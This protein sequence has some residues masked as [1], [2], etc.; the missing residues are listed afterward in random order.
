VKKPLLVT[1]AIAAALAFA[2]VANAGYAVAPPS[3]STTT[4]KPTFEVYLGPD[5][6]SLATVYVAADTQMS[7]YFTPVNELGS[8]TP[9]TPTATANQYTCQPNS[10]SN[11][12]FGPALPPGT[13]TWWLTFYHTDPGSFF[14]TLH[15]S[16]PLSFTVPQP[17]P[18]SGA[19]LIS[20]ADG[21]AVAAPVTFQ[22][23]AP[24]QATMHI[25][26]AITHDR[27][28]NGAPYVASYACGGATTNAGVYYCTDQT[29]TTD[30]IAGVTYYWWAVIN[31]GDSSFVYGP[32]AF[33]LTSGSSGGGGSGGG[34]GGSGGGGGTRTH[35][36]QDAPT[37]PSAA[38]YTGGSIKQT[39]LSAAAY[40]LS[41]FIGAPKSIAVA[42]W[43]TADWPT[44]SGDDAMT[45]GGYSTLAFWTP[46]MPHWVSLSPRVCGSMETLLHNRPA[47]PNRFT[48]N[49]V[50][51][52]THEMMHALG[53]N[54]S[55][56]GAA[57]EPI[58]ECY[59]MQLSIILAIQLGVPYRYAN[60]LS[61]YNLENYRL[62]PPSYQ[63]PSRCR[64][65][66]AWDLYPN[67]PSPP[68]H[69]FAL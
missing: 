20:P 47:Y 37:L 31:V 68:W 57:A 67:T 58:A 63:D 42:C 35:T 53:V 34:G 17:V 33:T 21:A 32:R 11:A 54:K 5:E 61:K 8:C 4:S 40:K 60:R 56:F 2:D 29:S 59:G 65:N 23:N 1:C 27:D 50:E 19:S 22:I 46:L 41:K 38:R 6:L 66:G 49:A 28:S 15:I 52:V 16:G 62:R 26:A 39:R 30:F 13:Y 25:Y 48:A 36:L 45:D 44:V 51:T 24:A 43:S 69:S 64:E 55:R 9:S 7:S 10:Y 3:G 14:S 12:G 18:P